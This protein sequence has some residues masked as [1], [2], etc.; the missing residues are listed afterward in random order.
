V[1][2]S[3]ADNYN[4]IPEEWRKGFSLK[5]AAVKR[6]LSN[7]DVLEIKSML[8]KGESYRTIWGIQTSQGKHCN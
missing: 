3:L 1:L 7:N 5:G 2:G 8:V 4:D 6:R